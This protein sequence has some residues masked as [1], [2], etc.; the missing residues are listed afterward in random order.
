MQPKWP[1]Y[2]YQFQYPCQNLQ[3]NHSNE[4][5][6]GNWQVINGYKHRFHGRMVISNSKNVDND[7]HSICQRLLLDILCSSNLLWL[8]YCKW[9][10]HSDVTKKLR[11]P[12]YLFM[13][14]YIDI[15]RVQLGWE[16]C[17]NA[18]H[19]GKS[20]SVNSI[21]SSLSWLILNQS[22]TYINS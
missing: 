2:W 14:K 20:I 3:K 21:Y 19:F 15:F 5:I 18:K 6:L 11:S 17:K 1:Q 22:P 12:V 4:K 13:L 7:G 9:G 16:R 10:T 8:L